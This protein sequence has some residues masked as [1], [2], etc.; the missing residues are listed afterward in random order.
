MS[1][2]PGVPL[3]AELRAPR[4]YAAFYENG[5]DLDTELSTQEVIGLLQQLTARLE[6]HEARY[7]RWASE[8]EAGHTTLDFMSWDAQQ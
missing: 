3:M 4:L 6:G 7:K 1:P 8:F 2:R 5:F